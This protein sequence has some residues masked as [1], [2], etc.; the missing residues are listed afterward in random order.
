[1]PRLLLV[2]VALALGAPR[3][4]HAQLL[5]SEPAEVTQTVDGTRVTIQYSRP[6]ARGRTGLFGTRIQDGHIWTPGA[7]AA[8]TL[9]VSKDV[10]INGQP[11]PKG[12]YSVWLAISRG[13]WE[14]ILDRDTTLFHTQGP[15][16]RTLQIR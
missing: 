14:M 9:A 1:M 7:N 16:R 4:M 2:L 3:T 8:T 10:T 15:H 12:K 13:E 6:R 5:A 11:V